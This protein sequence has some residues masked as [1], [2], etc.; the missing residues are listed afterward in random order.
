MHYHVQWLHEECKQCLL[1]FGFYN[2]K[3]KDSWEVKHKGKVCVR[4]VLI[5][6][7][8]NDVT[9][10]VVPPLRDPLVNNRLLHKTSFVKSLTH[11][12][13][14]IPPHL[15]HTLVRPGTNCCSL[16]TTS[17]HERGTMCKSLSLG[18]HSDYYQRIQ[19]EAIK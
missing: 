4:V 16:Q 6:W 13:W 19:P 3:E 12:T 8:T 11:S 1:K 10:T 15:R 18:L 17:L 2:L 9:C 14:G 7:T 5:R